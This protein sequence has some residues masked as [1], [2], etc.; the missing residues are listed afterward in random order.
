MKGFRVM[1]AY[2]L[3][4]ILFS[5]MV[6]TARLS[7]AQ[8]PPPVSVTTWHNDNWRTG[9]NTSETVLTPGDVTQHTVG[10]VTTETFGL[11]CKFTLSN[12]YSGW[13][14]NVYG[15]P[16]VV[17]NTDGSMTVYVVTMD[18]EAI[19]F[20]IPSGW[21]GNC[22][23]T[24]TL[25]IAITANSLIDTAGSEWPA[26]VCQIGGKK[27]ITIYPTIGI[28]GTPVIDTSTNTMYL[29]TESQ[30]GG[31][32][33]NGQNGT[34]CPGYNSDGKCVLDLPSTW[35]HK[36]HAL[37]L[38]PGSNFLKDKNTYHSPVLVSGMAGSATFN[39]GVQ[40]Q[41]PGLLWLSS[42]QSG[43]EHPMVY[44]AYSMMDGATGGPGTDPNGFVF[45]YDAANLTAAGYPLIYSPTSGNGADGGGIWEGGAGLAFGKDSSSGSNY[46]Y[47]PT[48]NGLFDL[49]NVGG[50]NGPDAG[51]SFVK[52]TTSLQ[53]PS[54][55]TPYFTPSDQYYRWCQDQDYGS[56]GV[57]LVPDGTLSTNPYLAINAEK[58]GNIWVMDRGSPGGFSLGSCDNQ[59]SGKTCAQETSDCTSQSNGVIQSLSGTSFHFHTS[60]AYWSGTGVTNDFG[61]LYYIGT[62]H[63]TLT[64]YPL[65]NSATTPICAGP[66]AQNTITFVSGATPSVSS[67]GHTNGIVWAIKNDGTDGNCNPCSSPGILYAFG[68]AAASIGSFQELYDSDQ[69]VISGTHVDRPGPATKFSVPTV[70]N[71]Y[72][73][74]GTQA[75]FDM[76]GVIQA[77]TCD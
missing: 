76:Y 67:D 42:S 38:T 51:D 73:F 52:L 47:F 61:Y 17:A 72:V 54:S 25:P 34:F 66:Y 5:G 64:Q 45:G 19:A 14:Y 59:N 33:C 8:A 20:G 1:R 55:G 35:Y 49:D 27:G 21:S 40:I 12:I 23:Q 74:I 46:I 48:G 69:C 28:L 41:R 30:Q 7:A 56:G 65:C 6:F 68:P 57:V 15:Q 53:L 77:R 3:A 62:N 43:Q 29:D 44:A 26:D 58:L 9:Q 11:L 32:R 36:L 63:P 13:S 2:A 22:A 70:A 16:L 60:P 71:G 24:G 18:D 10:T 4:A 50:T 75:D 31:S 37:D 39:T